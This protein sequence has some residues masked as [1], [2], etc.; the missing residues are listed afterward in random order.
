MTQ[1]ESAR[2][3][4]ITDEMAFVA[5]RENLEPELIRL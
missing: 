1:L 4:I 3:G 5:R 2:K